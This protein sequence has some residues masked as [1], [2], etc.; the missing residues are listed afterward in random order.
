M[1]F[2]A[3]RALPS[4]LR[5]AL[6]AFGV[7]TASALATAEAAPADFA[8]ERES[9]AIAAVPGYRQATLRVDIEPTSP[10]AFDFASLAVSDDA[11]WVAAEVDAARQ[12]LVLTFT[13]GTLVNATNE[14]TVTVASVGGTRTLRITAT[15]STPQVVAL[16]DDPVRSRMYGLHQNAN[17]LGAVL[18]FDPVNASPAPVASITVGNRPSDLDVSP[19]GTELAV[20]NATA[21]ASIMIVDLG[22]LTVK[23]TIPLPLFNTTHLGDPLSGH[24]AFGPAGVLYYVDSGWG[25]LLRVLRRSDGAVLQSAGIRGLVPN[26]SASN[27]VYGFGDFALSPDRKSLYGWARYGLHAGWAGSF[28]VR[29]TIGDDG[30]LAF[31]ENSADDYPTLLN[32]DPLDTPV[33]V[34]A[35]G[36]RVFMKQ[37]RFDADD[38]TGA[39]ALFSGPI[40]SISPGAELVATSQAIRNG[41]T[42]NV[43]RSL[44]GTY[45]VQAMSSDSTRFV[46]FDGLLRQLRS[47]DLLQAAGP[48]L[49]G[50]TLFPAHASVVSSPAELRWTPTPGADLYRVYLGSSA[51]EVQAATPGSSSQIGT[52]HGPRL[53]LPSPLAHGQSYHWRVE[54]VGPSGTTTGPV[55]SFTVSTLTIGRE[56]VETATVRGDP[57]HGFELG[58]GSLVPGTSWSVSS[59]A[60]WIRFDTATGVTPATLHLT[61]DASA[62][63]AGVH[64]SKVVVQSPEGPIDL[65]V[66]LHVDP[67]AITRFEG[68]PGDTKH[69][70]LSEQGFGSVSGS[71]Y[72]ADGT[73]AYLLE[74]DV[75]G[76]RITRAVR[77]GR[78]ATDLALHAAD[79]RVYVANW[80]AGRVLAVSLA[81]FAVVR[82]FPFPT[83]AGVGYSAGDAY[84]LSAGGPGRLVVEPADQWVSISLL[85]TMTGQVLATSFERA[86]DGAYAPDKRH[87]YHGDSNSSGA[88]LHRFDT[89]GDVF[90]RLASA[91][92]VG[93]SYYGSRTVL[94][95]DDGERI[96]WN[97][98]AFD[99]ALNPL[100]TTTHEVR[101][102]SGDGRYAF[103][104][105]TIH[106]T[107]TPTIV[108]AV[109]VAN[110]IYGFNS[111]TGR[112]LTAKSGVL[113]FHAVPGIDQPGRTRDPADGAVILP[114]STLS[115]TPLA[116]ASGY[117]VYLGQNAAAVAAATPDSPEYLGQVSAATITL[118]ELLAAGQTHH[119]RIDIVFQGEVLPGPV[120]SFRVTQ[121]L[122]ATNP[123]EASTVRGHDSLP[124]EVALASVTAGVPWTASS[125][126]SW[127]KVTKPSGETP[128]PL[129]LELDA[130]AL[131]PG[132]H[133]GTVTLVGGEETL[134]LPVRLRVDPL[135]LTVL[136]SDP[137]SAFVYGLSESSNTSPASA[138]LIEI[139]AALRRISRVIPLAT[140]ASDLAVHPAE[141]RLYVANWTLGRLLSFDQTTL[142]PVATFTDFVPSG[143]SGHTAYSISAGAAGRLVVEGKSGTVNVSLFDTVSGQFLATNAQREGGGAFHPAGRHYFH[144]D[145]NVE[146]PRL[147]R[148][149]TAGDQLL[150]VNLLGSTS[151]GQ[152]DNFSYYGSR[153]VVMSEDG[154]RVFWNGSAF[155]TSPFALEWWIK[156]HILASSADGRLAFSKGKLLDVQ[157]RVTLLTFPTQFPALAYNSAAD[158][159]VARSGGEV[160]YRAVG[161]K[162]PLL[163]PVASVTGA[164]HTWLALGWDHANLRS[165]TEIE[166]R[167]AGEDAW[168]YA[169][170]SLPG[171]HSYYFSLLEPGTT[172]EFRTR[173]LHPLGA[174]PWSDVVTGATLF[175]APSFTLA[176]HYLAKPGRPFTLGL[177]VQAGWSYTVEGLPPGIVF[178]PATGALT[179]TPTQP[180]RHQVTVRATNPGGSTEVKFALVVTAPFSAGAKARH[181]GLLTGDSGLVG[182]WS[183]QRS[184]DDLTG[185]IRLN[186]P[187]GSFAGR[188]TGTSDGH[189]LATLQTKLDKTT[190]SLMAIL[191][192]ATDRLALT[193]HAADQVRADTTG[194][195]GFPVPWHAKLKPYPAPGDYNTLLALVVPDEEA[196]PDAPPAPAP[197]GRGFL[198]VK[199]GWDGIASATGLNAL[200]Q[201]VA[202]R[203]PL[204]HNRLLPF[205]HNHDSGALW[206]VI[207]FAGAAGAQTPAE[208]APAVEGLL[209]W[210]RYPAPAKPLYPAGFSRFVRVVGSRHEPTRNHAAL[211]ASGDT[212]SLRLGGDRFDTFTGS[213]EA[214]F[215]QPLG[216]LRDNFS[217]PRPGPLNP[218]AVKFTYAP[219]TGLI[220]GS[221][222]FHEPHPT[223]AR[224]VKRVVTFRGLAVQDIDGKGTLFGGGHFLLSDFS[225]RK[226]SGW[227]S[228]GRA[229]ESYAPE[230]DASVL[231]D[232][233]AP[234]P[235]RKSVLVPDS[236]APVGGGT[237]GTITIG[238][239]GSNSSWSGSGSVTYG[240]VMMLRSIDYS[241]FTRN[242]PP[243][244]WQDIY[245]ARHDGTIQFTSP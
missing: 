212:F 82:S 241:D 95:S 223:T 46:Y 187:A 116:G 114:P 143:G 6:A 146:S 89:V 79:G 36:K 27:A 84:R 16:A 107:V 120:Q 235:M 62:L 157:A 133:T 184:G 239:G 243:P 3:F 12:Q 236:P 56:R 112:L 242:Q 54:A 28:A 2:G 39:D 162:L 4:L 55:H 94:V 233:A 213:D 10:D 7:T 43:V 121:L 238:T 225:K 113:A 183:I 134:T 219:A 26:D 173:S 163:T 188:F 124:V 57:S 208:P 119:W 71:S 161:Y 221:A 192:P 78:G 152:Y 129:R 132:L 52:S 158:T 108:G 59:P 111:A 141:G 91:R 142:A 22:T 127:I 155:T 135:A 74:I 47:V 44:G 211:A 178:D 104:D 185:Q 160:A 222:T 8:L 87:Y 232:A 40:Y 147:R 64:D 117:R 103:T 216:F 144:G 179:G 154:S 45:P 93:L 195:T 149:D 85:D 101:A 131:T 229:E 60:A 176:P 48:A 218:H 186:G 35:D 68:R 148:F 203:G 18:V 207:G 115:W 194:G 193:L 118:S 9:L 182:F 140:G 58:L 96:F 50:R 72:P 69:Y 138:Y 164:G 76:E 125:P 181:V 33:L 169:F 237:G 21:P 151:P 109:P 189:R 20:I 191:D 137:D 168:R 172:Y 1:H 226:H 126:Q 66:R 177:P 83:F 228:F 65:P 15:N 24:V 200:G 67:L 240:S 31:A 41:A 139:D 166:W 180:G 90:T 199:I 136:R 165:G 49:L 190:V 11:A 130:S 224:P 5:L 105:T 29:F 175:H 97:G 197:A 77:V 106:D 215:V 245:Q 23:E 92:A 88:K 145:N 196:E 231:G 14:A 81:D 70:A 37:A 156:D 220:T 98:V 202:F 63:V 244:G 128:E 201:R 32:R 122:P 150:Q 19:D 34:S 217:L 171:T 167:E 205:F 80:R 86:G 99:P 73:R 209:A 170:A 174:S 53:A 38:L 51:A 204:Q 17:G 227:M 214:E 75:L 123:V 230:V 159:M 153:G 198:R 234:P 100:W 206:G 102:I 61:L 210:G 30:L 110:A 42:G 13:T 25:P